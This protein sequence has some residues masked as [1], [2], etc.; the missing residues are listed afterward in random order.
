MLP[1]FR[2]KLRLAAVTFESAHLY[3][4]AGTPWQTPRLYR[5]STDLTGSSPDIAVISQLLIAQAYNSGRRLLPLIWP[6]WSK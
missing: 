5:F 4:K 1:S 3:L 2:L 6:T